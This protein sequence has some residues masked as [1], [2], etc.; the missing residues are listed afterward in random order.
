MKKFRGIF[1]KN[2]HEIGLL[3]EANRI[4]AEILEAIEVKLTPGI[5]AS[6]IERLANEVCD[7]YKVKP[8]F[9]G[10][11]G[12]PYSICCSVNEEIVHGFPTDRELKDGDIVSFDM[13]TVY[14]GFHG[15]AA[16][17]FAVGKVTENASRLME[18]TQNAL[19][20]GIEQAIPGNDLYDIS[21]AVETEAKKYGYQIIKRFVGHGIG[22][23]LHERPEI[24]NFVPRRANRT[25]LKPGMA[26]AI[27]PM[28]AEGTDEVKILDDGWTAVTK[29]GSLSA[30]FEHTIAITNQGPRILSKL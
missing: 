14:K 16:R 2:E 23:K 15:D 4:V 12:F 26:L 8:A 5:L 20:K 24:P 9:R 1:I 6:E 13:G 25:P 30:H 28:L 21:R 18:A 22:A 11:C 27:E 7:K 17:T 29:D 3:R 10:Y 19:E